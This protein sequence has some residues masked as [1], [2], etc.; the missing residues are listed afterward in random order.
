M[1]IFKIQFGL[2]TD[3][4]AVCQKIKQLNGDCLQQS[5]G[6]VVTIA[7]NENELKE[8]LS[9]LSKQFTLV[10]LGPES[11]HDESLSTDAQLFIQA[12]KV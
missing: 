5:A 3:Q 12:A 9:P 1:N 4:Q 11:I 7:L 6:L 8:E 10:K 2:D